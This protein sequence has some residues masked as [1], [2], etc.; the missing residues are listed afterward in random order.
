MDGDGIGGSVNLKTKTAGETPIFGLTALGGRNSILGGRLNDQ[1][2]ATIGR[3]FLS[4]KRLGVLFGASYDWNGRGIDELD[5]SIDPAS[6]PSRIL[7]K[8]DTVREYEYYRTRWGGSGSIDYKFN[9][10]TDIYING[11]YSVFRL[12]QGPSL[13]CQMGVFTRPIS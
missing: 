5:P 11:I 8:S 13:R 9:G 7:Y 10:F 2:N 1:L 6:T 12:F 4:S 3:R